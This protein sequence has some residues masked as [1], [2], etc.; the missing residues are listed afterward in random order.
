MN[1]QLKFDEAVLAAVQKNLSR[2]GT[3][4]LA[5]LLR[6][7]LKKQILDVNQ[8]FFDEHHIQ[9]IQPKVDPKVK[10]TVF[11]CTRPARVWAFVDL[12]N[13]RAGDAFIVDLEVQVGNGDYQP[14]ESYLLEGQRALPVAMIV[15][16]FVPAC[17]LRVGQTLGLTKDFTVEIFARYED[18]G[19][20]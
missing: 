9:L 14:C 17:R 3:K 8:R 7:F 10:Y 19:A 4:E 13:A 18:A 5:D 1:L 20:A 6:P 12:V 15:D 11:E 2:I 16:R